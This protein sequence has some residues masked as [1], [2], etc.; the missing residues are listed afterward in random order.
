MEQNTIDVKTRDGPSDR[1][2][3]VQMECEPNR[4]VFSFGDHPDWALFREILDGLGGSYKA[5]RTFSSGTPAMSEIV[6]VM[7]AAM[8][9]KFGLVDDSA[10]VEDTVSQ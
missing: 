4:L 6:R 3:C 9:E 2:M 1:S 8:E 5:R 7:V 10:D